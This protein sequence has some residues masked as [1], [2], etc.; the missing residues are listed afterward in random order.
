MDFLIRKKKLNPRLG[1]ASGVPTLL[2]EKGAL[3]IA[4]RH[5]QTS[6]S[7]GASLSRSSWTI[8][9]P[10]L[11]KLVFHP[12]GQ[13]EMETMVH[14]AAGR[15][16]RGAP[17]KSVKVISRSGPVPTQWVVELL[18][19]VS[20]VETGVQGDDEADYLSGDEDSDEDG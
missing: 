7:F 18:K 19:H 3:V 8:V 2:P 6:L 16:K 17:L 5:A 11:K 10:K 15:A 13:F 4:H 14:V 12:F 1:F 20:R 9:C